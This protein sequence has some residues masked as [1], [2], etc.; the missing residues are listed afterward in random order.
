MEASLGCNSLI[1]TG[2]FE[3]LVFDL[4]TWLVLVASIEGRNLEGPDLG[5]C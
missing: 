1:E 3:S 4:P 5:K 2:V